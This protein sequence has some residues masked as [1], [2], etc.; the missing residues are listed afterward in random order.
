VSGATLTFVTEALHPNP[1]AGSKPMSVDLRAARSAETARAEPLPGSAGAG[2]EP[3]LRPLSD[4]AEDRGEGNLPP[5]ED[6]YHRASTHASPRARLSMLSVMSVMAPLLVGPV[7]ALAGIFFGWY[8]RQEI[9]ATGSRKRGYGLATLGL[10]L[11][12][13]TTVLWGAGLSFAVWAL[14]FGDERKAVAAAP[15]ARTPMLWG[16]KP[17]VASTE[18]VPAAPEIVIPKIT[19]SRREGAITMVDV[20]MA[21]TS[22]PEAFAKQRAEAA[23]AGETMLV[24]ATAGR[25][26]PC[27]AVDDALRAPLMQTA[28][29]GVRVV[30][31]DVGAFGEDLAE[32]KIP[33]DKIPGFYLLGLDLTPRDGING[34]EWDEDTARNIAPVLGAFVRGK[35]ASRR[36]AWKSPPILGIR[37]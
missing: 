4:G 37:L 5:L 1:N 24:M 18:A 30:R 12:I 29:F 15:P 19:T 33:I 13:V 9:Q 16:R 35:Y 34:G 2:S 21:V 11:G 26:E 6:P 8:A 3:A 17:A 23:R 7:G 27:Q 28:L 31:V 20:G 10:S 22:L 14:R 36:E 32:L 25:C